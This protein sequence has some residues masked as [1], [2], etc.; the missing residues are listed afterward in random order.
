MKIKLSATVA[1]ALQTAIS[2]VLAFVSRIQDEASR[3]IISSLLQKSKE[4]VTALAD[5]D[6]EDNVQIKKIANSLV[7]DGDFFLG[8][9]MLIT[10]GLDKIPAPYDSILHQMRNQTWNLLGLMTDDNPAN[11]EQMKALLKGWLH[12]PEGVDFL[13]NL[14]DIA[15]KEE[16]ADYFGAILAQALRTFIPDERAL[17]IMDRRFAAL[18]PDHSDHS[19]PMISKAY[20]GGD[21]P[22]DMPAQFKTN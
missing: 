2:I 19:D 22:Y 17:S 15:L 12:S 7:S 5:S 3:L 1:F 16:D 11:G 20:V 6:P 21:I 10:K 9:N 4:A 18:M 14:L 13:Q 8:S